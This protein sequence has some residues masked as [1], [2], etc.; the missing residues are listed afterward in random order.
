MKPAF[1]LALFLVVAGCV[2]SADLRVPLAEPASVGGRL[3]IVRLGTVAVSPKDEEKVGEYVDGFWE[4]LRTELSEV[5]AFDE[6]EYVDAPA[7]F[8]APSLRVLAQRAPLGSQAQGWARYTLRVP[9]DPA[10]LAP[11]ADVVVVMDTVRVAHGLVGNPVVLG[12]HTGRVGVT[13]PPLNTRGLTVSADALVYR[14]GRS[15][16]TGAGRISVFGPSV[17]FGDRVDSGT[18]DRAV[19]GFAERIAVHGGFAR[20]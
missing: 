1:A 19:A 14:S 7:A 13:A 18:A 6:V 2:P 16:P 17:G 3:A 8:E 4:L 20:R 10:Q 9:V 12:L 11:E 5:Y 15:G